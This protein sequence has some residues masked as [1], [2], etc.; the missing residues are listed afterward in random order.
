MSIESFADLVIRT[1]G[2]PLQLER[3]PD[4]EGS[5][6]RRRPDIGLAVSATSYEPCVR[7]TDWLR[8]T[9]LWYLDNVFDAEQCSPSPEIHPD[10]AWREPRL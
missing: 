9:Y 7:L 3:G 1:V 8:R 4:T 10:R 2:K 6:E 5:P